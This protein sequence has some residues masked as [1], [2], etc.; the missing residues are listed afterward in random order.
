MRLGLTT[1]AMPEEVVA[2][3]D[4]EQR[5]LEVLEKDQSD[6]EL[7][8]E[9]SEPQQVSELDKIA[10]VTVNHRKHARESLQ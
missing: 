2:E 9:P 5:L 4:D 8:D 10:D 1:T 3:I 6:E 7:Y